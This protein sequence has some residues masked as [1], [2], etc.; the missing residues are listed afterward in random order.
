MIAQLVNSRIEE[1]EGRRIPQ[2]TWEMPSAVFPSHYPDV[3]AFFRSADQ[4]ITRTGFE[5]IR[6]AR[7]FANKYFGEMSECIQVSKSKIILKKCF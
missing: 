5:N 3:I 4:Q 2:F 1:L 7:N 6:H